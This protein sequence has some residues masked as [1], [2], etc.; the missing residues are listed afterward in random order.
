MLAEGVGFEPTRRL[1]ACRF[2]RPVPSTTRSPLRLGQAEILALRT[3]CNAEV[4]LISSTAGWAVVW[5][6]ALSN[7]RVAMTSASV[8]IAHLSLPSACQ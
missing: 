6:R 4:R 1:P 8:D 5:D 3:N 7:I 2:S